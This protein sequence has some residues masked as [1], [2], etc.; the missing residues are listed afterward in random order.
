LA[1]YVKGTFN[2]ICA[3]VDYSDDSAALAM[4]WSL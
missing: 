1:Q 2:T 3:P 4:A